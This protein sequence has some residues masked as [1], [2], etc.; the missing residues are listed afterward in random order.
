MSALGNDVTQFAN[1]D[2][3]ADPRYF[4]EFL[5]ARKSFEGER[6]VKELIIEMLDLKPGLDVL[7]VGSGAGDDAREIASIVGPN[8]RVTGIDLNET[9]VA[10]S[11]KRAAESGSPAEFRRGD[12]RALDLPSQSFDRVRTDRVLMFV[13]EID[14]AIAEIVR[15]LRPGGRVAASEIDHETH[16]I[17]SDRPD[18]SRKFHA[19]FATSHPQPRLGRGLHRLLAKYGLR[20]VKTV[21]RVIRPPYAMF[22]TLFGG[23]I[24]SAIAR[25]RLDKAEMDTLLGELATFD[26][27]CLY[28]GGVTVFTATAEKP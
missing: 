9:L 18:I 15:V 21:P 13:P 5:D 12:A 4:I 8:G 26:R 20:N 28:N 1:V 14:K 24:A 2:R 27:S 23:F 16:F 3:A 22:Q 7:D 10:E 11:R 25:G 6:A 17:D 19:A